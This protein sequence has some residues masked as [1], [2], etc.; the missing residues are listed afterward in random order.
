[1]RKKTP[2]D[3]ARQAQP[4]HVLVQPQWTVAQQ[5]VVTAPVTVEGEY[6]HQSRWV[7]IQRHP[8]LFTFLSI[9]LAVVLLW[10][11][12]VLQFIQNTLLL[13]TTDKVVYSQVA[14]K[15]I[16]VDQ[17]GFNQQ[18][19]Q[20]NPLSVPFPTDVRFIELPQKDSKGVVE[21]R[22]QAFVLTRTL[23]GTMQVNQLSGD[24]VFVASNPHQLKSFPWLFLPPDKVVEKLNI[25]LKAWLKKQ[26]PPQR[27]DDVY[28]E[29]NTLFLKIKNCQIGEVACK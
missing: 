26:N 27:L 6:N 22:I 15:V 3:Q 9:L 19:T 13:I 1:L 23:Q 12:V 4:F 21:V 11:L 7:F 5:P 8:V 18:I 10:N 20:A 25:K 24:L 17:R 14:S 29:G 28:I 16:M 2:S